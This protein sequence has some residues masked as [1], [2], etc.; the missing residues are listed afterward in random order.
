MNPRSEVS[1]PAARV[2]KGRRR[3][4]VSYLR[5]DRFIEELV[6]TRHEVPSTPSLRRRKRPIRVRPEWPRVTER[7]AL[8]ALTDDVRDGVV[9]V[10]GRPFG[11]IEALGVSEL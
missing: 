2:R 1:G 8:H 11:M 9:V 7:D 4:R 10:G 5:R 3:E 6:S